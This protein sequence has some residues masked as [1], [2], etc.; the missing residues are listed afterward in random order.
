MHDIGFHRGKLAKLAHRF[1][2]KK[3]IRSHSLESSL[4]RIAADLLERV[5]HVCN[6]VANF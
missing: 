5:A 2:L 1:V 4:L 6:I 3:V